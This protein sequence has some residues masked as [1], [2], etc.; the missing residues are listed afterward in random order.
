MKSNK[1]ND[2]AQSRA[3]QVKTVKENKKI[4]VKYV[5]LH[6]KTVK[7][8]RAKNPRSKSQIRYKGDSY[9]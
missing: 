8:Y 7:I 5:K 3:L 4:M 2:M 9:I 1:S 6:I